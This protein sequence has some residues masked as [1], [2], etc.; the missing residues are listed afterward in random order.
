MKSICIILLVFC[1]VALGQVQVQS[2]PPVRVRNVQPQQQSQPLDPNTA[3]PENYQLTLNVSDGDK[4][5]TELSVIAVTPMFTITGVEPN[6]TF[7]GTITPEDAGTVLVAYSVS[8]DVPVRP[9]E[10][11]AS[12]TTQY[13]VVGAQ[14]AARLRLG[15]TLQILK[16][17]TRTFKLTVSKLEAAKK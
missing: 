16:S 7:A 5:A 13:R 3:L 17:G 8:G 10:G 11:A 15:E 1:G 2:P 12:N 4:P 14:A 6:I 9:P